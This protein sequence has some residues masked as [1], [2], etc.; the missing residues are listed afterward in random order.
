MSGSPTP[1]ALVN[2]L[3]RVILASSPEFAVRHNGHSIGSRLLRAA[4]KNGFLIESIRLI[5]VSLCMHT[6]PI[7][8]TGYLK[9]SENFAR[10]GSR[11]GESETYR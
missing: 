1:V 5:L 9:I 11:A 2:P 10:R 6:A 3:P 4:Y 8:M 7:R